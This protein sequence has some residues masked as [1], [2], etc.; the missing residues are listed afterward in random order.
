MATAEFDFNMTINGNME[1]TKRILEVMHKYEVGEKVAYFNFVEVDVDG[2]EIDLDDLDSFDLEG[3]VNITAMGPYGRYMFLNDVD[4]FR[5]MAE[6]APNSSFEA[7][8]TGGT[9]YT[10]QSLNCRLEKGI[11]HIE[12]YFLSN[13]EEPD[14]Y[15]EYFKQ[16]VPYTDFINH[17]E[18]DSEEFDEC[19]YEDLINNVF[20]YFE[21]EINDID[22]DTFIEELDID[23]DEEKYEEFIQNLEIDN[24]YD[25]IDDYD[26]GEREEYKYDPINKC[27]INKKNLEII[28]SKV[29]DVNK[30]I[31][32]Y[33]QSQGLPYDDEYI[34]SLS[35]EEVYEIVMKILMK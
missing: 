12:T 35:V 6:I 31:K 13:E 26:G 11:L 20:V 17:F 28:S 25:F 2:E 23:I 3:E 29:Q 27:Y 14:A 19:A 10:E 22:Y 21:E 33:L 34:S 9:T 8:I 7:E 5:D 4:I 30:D 24:Y 32:E 1:D 16:K 18:I 15:I